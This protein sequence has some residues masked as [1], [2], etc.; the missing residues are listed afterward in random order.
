[1]AFSHHFGFEQTFFRIDVEISVKP[2]RF[3]GRGRV[4]R[5]D[6]FIGEI[7]LV[8]RRNQVQIEHWTE[9]KLRRSVSGVAEDMVKMRQWVTW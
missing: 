2:E 3:T 6:E 4:Y 9:D 5:N 1:M 7:P 8:G